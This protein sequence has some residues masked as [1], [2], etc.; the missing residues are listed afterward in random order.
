MSQNFNK[1]KHILDYYTFNNN[2]IQQL[3][4]HQYY[5][6]KAKIYNKMHPKKEI[7]PKKNEDFYIPQEK[8][9]VFWC[10]IIF[11]Y[12]F[13]EYEILKENTFTTEKNYKIN[14]IDKIRKNKQLLKQLKVK[15]VDIE[16]NLANESILNIK[17]LEPMLI[18]DKFNFVF[19]NDKIY[20]E[21]ITFPGNK[22]CIIKYFE[23]EEK[24]GIFLEEEKLFEYKNKLFIVDNI[25][26][27]IKNISNYKA[28]DL[29]DICKKLNIN[30]MK[31]PTKTKTK[32]ELY[33]LVI[34]KI[35]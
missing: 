22:S 35:I 1:I 6:E 9:S 8:D 10:W 27:P 28:Q 26:K 23:K 11:L 15:T 3:M 19:M 16:S 13:S 14:F 18:I 2:N 30:I 33:Q 34:E 24:Y 21:N 31:T 32:K 12:G 4:T 25:I 29:K 20:F 17:N 7:K 5:Q